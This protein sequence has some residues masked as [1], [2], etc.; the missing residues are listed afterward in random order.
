ME[1]PPPQQRTS[2]RVRIP[3]DMNDYIEDTSPE[4]REVEERPKRKAIKQG[5]QRGPRER[6]LPPSVQSPS[7]TPTQS[8]LPSHHRHYEMGD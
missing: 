1:E 8:P 7:A 5:G 3:V 6:Q 4:A 2:G